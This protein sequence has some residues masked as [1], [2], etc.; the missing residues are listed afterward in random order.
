MISQ[1]ILL[2]QYVKKLAKNFY[3]NAKHI[4]IYVMIFQTKIV[5]KIK[6]KEI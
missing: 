2:I 5:N 1:V 3:Q 6:I 4:Q